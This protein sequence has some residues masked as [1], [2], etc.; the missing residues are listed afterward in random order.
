M[1]EMFPGA[2]PTNG[3]G[4][5]AEAMPPNVR[6]H[7]QQGEPLAFLCSCGT[8]ACYGR[9]GKWYCAVCWLRQ[10]KDA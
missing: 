9:N 5:I 1:S 3:V 10:A 4:R 8:D 7:G 6:G 2:G